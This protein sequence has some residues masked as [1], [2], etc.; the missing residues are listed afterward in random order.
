MNFQF[1]TNVALAYNTI[2]D[3]P[4]VKINEL[5]IKSICVQA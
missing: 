2:I 3:E 5:Y 4:S 1:S